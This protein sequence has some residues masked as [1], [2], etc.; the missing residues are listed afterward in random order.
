MKI[1]LALALLIAGLGCAREAPRDSVVALCTRVVQIHL[2]VPGAVEVAG[3]PRQTSEGNVEM[4]F[5]ATDAMNTPVEGNAVCTFD[6]REGGVLY[7]VQAIVDGQLL[8]DEE[9][10]DIRRQIGE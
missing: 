2:G 5:R 3:V 8:G 4:D 1:P 10:A 7:L 9:I 6:I